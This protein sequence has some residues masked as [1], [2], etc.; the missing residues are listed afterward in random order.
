MQLVNPCGRLCVV[1]TMEKMMTD[2]TSFSP[3]E[4]RRYI[5][6][7]QGR[8][9]VIEHMEDAFNKGRFSAWFGRGMFVNHI[10][11][12]MFEPV[13]LCGNSC[14]ETSSSPIPT[15][16][17]KVCGR[18]LKLY[19]KSF[20]SWFEKKQET[21]DRSDKAL[22]QK[23]ENIEDIMDDYPRTWHKELAGITF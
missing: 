5:R 22:V 17:G 2:K 20:I 14:S 16:I 19:R 9:E 8:K 13:A 18:C 3:N 21:V 6:S 23:I 4:A 12:G 10:T 15:P 11:F 7:A 1:I